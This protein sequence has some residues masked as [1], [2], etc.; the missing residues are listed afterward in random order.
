MAPDII[1]NVLVFYDDH[2]SHEVLE[3]VRLLPEDAREILML[4]GR[5]ELTY[6]EMAARFGY[7]VGTVQSRLSRAR[8]NLARRLAAMKK[9]IWGANYRH[10]LPVR[11]GPGLQSE[12]ATNHTAQPE[13]ANATTN[14][15]AS[16]ARL[17]QASRPLMVG[18]CGLASAP[19]NR[20][21]E[22]RAELSMISL[23]I[24]SHRALRRRGP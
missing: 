22:M 13:P 14:A 4:A 7:A 16:V 5:E 19:R 23:T 20:V 6:Q 15:P 8:A 24:P 1:E 21:E 11:A 3:A 17:D 9:P 10:D 2:A 12:V 18:A